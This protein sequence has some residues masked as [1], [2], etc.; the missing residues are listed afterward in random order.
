MGK[1]HKKT[2]S[3]PVYGGIERCFLMP[4]KRIEL[5]TFTLYLL[6]FVDVIESFITERKSR[7]LSKR[8]I[9]YYQLEL[10]QFKSWLSDNGYPDIESITPDAIRSYLLSMENRRNAGGIH[11]SYRAIK[12]ILNWYDTEYEP[13]GWKNPIKKWSAPGQRGNHCQG[14]QSQMLKRWCR[15]VS[16]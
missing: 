4:Q 11:A 10:G 15:N 6:T 7:R 1:T 5:L 16:S 12:A 13:E 8:T 14:Y 3:H 2:P 9:E